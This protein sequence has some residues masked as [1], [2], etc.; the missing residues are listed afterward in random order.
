MDVD[1]SLIKGLIC[2]LTR[3][4]FFNLITQKSFNYNDSFKIKKTVAEG[5]VIWNP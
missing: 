3:I 2:N 5:I 4:I 1:T